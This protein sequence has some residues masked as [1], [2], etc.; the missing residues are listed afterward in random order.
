MIPAFNDPAALRIWEGY[1]ADVDRLLVRAGLGE[2]GLRG[3]LETHVLDS[4]AQEPDET[5][6]IARLELA[7]ARL[8]RPIDYLRPAIADELIHR[9]SLTFRPA[10]LAAGLYHAL[11]AG[12]K[13]TITAMAFGLGYLMLA[14]FMAMALLKPFWGQNVGLFRYPDGGVSVGVVARTAGTHEL[15]GWS[16]IPL[17]LAMAAVLYFGLAKGL[18]AL[19]QRK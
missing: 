7:L 6:Q 5:S 12:S 2:T 8:G 18:R 1:F 13:R 4:M 3:D 10:V 16:V 17:A 9:G 14:I 15:L 11:K 19:V